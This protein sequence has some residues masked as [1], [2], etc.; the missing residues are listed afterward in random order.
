MLD[1]FTTEFPTKKKNYFP[2][3]LMTKILFIFVITGQSTRR[4]Y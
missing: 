2:D 1:S 4:E 3:L